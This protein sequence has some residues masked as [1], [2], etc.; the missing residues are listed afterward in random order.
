M[1]GGT[2]T[3]YTHP[4]IGDSLG[5]QIEGEGKMNY[6][7]DR[8]GDHSATCLTDLPCLWVLIFVTVRISSLL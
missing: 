3:L 5:T 4:V 7:P 2:R 1:S 8:T 6:L